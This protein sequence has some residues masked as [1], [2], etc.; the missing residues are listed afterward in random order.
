MSKSA[1][2]SLVSDSDNT[3]SGSIELETSREGVIVITLCDPH[4]KIHIK[5]NLLIDTIEYVSK[6]S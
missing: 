4:R 6:D 5:T 1:K 3:N 2:I